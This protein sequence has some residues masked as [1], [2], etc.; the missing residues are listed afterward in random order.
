VLRELIDRLASLTRTRA[1][2]ASSRGSAQGAAER[3]IAEGNRAEGRGQLREACARYRAAVET[4]PEYATAHLNL[5]IG[6]EAIGDAEGA[7]KS[8][9]TARSLAPANAYASYNLGRLRYAGGALLEAE[10]LLLSALDRKPE[11]PEASV[12]L[13][14]VYSA[15][16]KLGAAAAALETALGQRPDD[17]GA[18]CAHATIV[19]RLGKSAEAESALRRA[20]AADP[21][22]V[23]ATSLLGGVLAE[24][25]KWNEA[26]G[27]Y[28]RALELKPDSPEINTDLGNLLRNRGRLAEAVICHRR[29][30]AL[31][32]DFAEAHA[33]LGHALL[34]QGL[35]EESMACY[36]KAIELRPD[37]AQAHA[38]LGNALATDQRR[39]DEAIACY[40]KALGLEPDLPEAHYN[41]GN[42]LMFQNRHD[43]ALECYRKVLAVD[44]ENIQARWMLTICQ[45]PMVYEAGED[46]G[47]YRAAFSARL[48]ELDRWFDASRAAKGFATV[49]V[50]QPFCL[51]YQEENNRDLLQ[52]YGKLC[53]RLMGAWL[54]RE[55]VALPGRRGR[56]GVI[57]VG[58]VSQ[59]F[60]NHSV[61]NAIVKGWFHQLDRERFAVYAF[62]LGPRRDEE[63]Q[64]AQS[65][66]TRFEQGGR[67]LRQWVESILGEQLDVL[68]YPEVGM[69]PMTLKLASLRLAP[70][71][72]A[73][74]GHPETS[75]LP[76]ID[77]Y[78]S[79]EDM[80]PP[81][82]QANYTEQL[83][84]LPRLGCFYQA[85][86]IDPPYADLSHWGIG[87]DIPLLVCPGM[88]FK[89]APQH[90]WIFAEIARRA[91]RCRLIFFTPHARGL[92]EKLRQ[93]L[94]NA[95][96]RS[97][98]DIDR[99]VSFIPWQ[100][101][102][103]FYGLLRRA[104]VFLDTIGF[105]GFNT[106]ME[107]VECGLPIVTREG[108][109]LRGRFASGIL[110]RMGLHELVAGSDEDYV[111]LS[112]RLCQDAGYREHVRRRIEA[113]RHVLYEDVAPIRA[114][115]N[116][117][118]G[119]T[120]RG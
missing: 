55:G 27:C 35:V 59:Y 76:T 91:P 39:L 13:A 4:A 111:A 56:N 92:S 108:R 117:L 74:W 87:P 95:F 31:R 82:A 102:A 61:W 100:P 104:D 8:Y 113:G 58:I 103:V 18:L 36:R 112:V 49:G 62:H 41:L 75:G 79:A 96:A 98:L 114:F 81:G 45:L 47:R 89:Y 105:S 71:Q 51:A 1:P 28:E 37:F 15:Q 19:R 119:A 29:A 2:G 9:E 70:V 26:I 30:L 120:A 53:A 110:K 42:A 23:D 22:S 44:S 90:D 21:N 60:W 78:L 80:E 5:G 14:H 11:F 88:P 25:G 54:D 38:G 68:I 17:I 106:A 85:R 20:I 67:G 73:T 3:L 32:P 52:R 6:L 66:A 69:D 64:F 118:A 34:D 101:R 99:F 97:G 57:R 24:Q 93:R 46:P 12:T 109:F 16:G 116:F 10:R 63:T 33:D 40:R 94:E 77:Y 107:A 48:D 72:A 7:M 86:Q 65:R 115:E 84:A 83:V 50:H 43:E